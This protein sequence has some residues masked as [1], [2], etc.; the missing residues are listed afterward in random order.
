[1]LLNCGVGAGFWESRGHQGDQTSQY[2]RKSTLN[3]HW[4]DWCWSLSSSTLVTWCEEP[5]HWKRSW[6]CERLKAKRE[7]SS[8][9]WDGWMASPTQWTWIWAYSGR[10]WSTG[11]PGMLQSIGLQRIRH[12]LATEQQQQQYEIGLTFENHCDSAHWQT[13]IY[14]HIYKRSCIYTWSSQ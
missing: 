7:E 3:I 12:N 10:Q 4:K 6:C 2:S 8:R 9:D 1:M 14:I 13:K 5:T 11:K